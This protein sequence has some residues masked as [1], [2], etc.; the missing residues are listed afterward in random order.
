MFTISKKFTFEAAHR[1]LHLP[2]DHPCTR[3]HGHSY[4][5]KFSFASADLD[6]AGMV[7]DFRKL[8]VI[9]R[10]IDKTLDHQDLNI[11]LVDTGKISNTT[12]E[13]LAKYFY[14][15]YCAIFNGKLKSVT[16]SE[17]PKTCATYEPSYDIN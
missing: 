3:P 10:D 5:V 4:V 11:Q 16:V 13:L 9:K 6:K 8:D 1:L 17:T 7:I 2:E 15:T 14:N 12:S